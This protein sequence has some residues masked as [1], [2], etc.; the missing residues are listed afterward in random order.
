MLSYSLA[1]AAFTLLGHTGVVS[2]LCRDHQGGRREASPSPD[3]LLG[4]APP[5]AL[6]VGAEDAVQRE[7][8]GPP[9]SLPKPGLPARS[10]EAPSGLTTRAEK[11]DV[12][13]SQSSHG[14]RAAS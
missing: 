1:V 3:P 8:R 14:K 12:F 6:A 4:A 11:K 10:Q 13:F 7:P 9:A 2:T 5:E